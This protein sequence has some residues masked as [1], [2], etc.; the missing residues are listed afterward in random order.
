MKQ[1][2]P[3]SENVI[4][5]SKPNPDGSNGGHEYSLYEI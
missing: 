2:T 1:S 4:P 5:V 3:E